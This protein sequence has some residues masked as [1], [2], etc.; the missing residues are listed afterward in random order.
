MYVSVGL[1]ALG[2]LWILHG[3]FSLRRLNPLFDYLEMAGVLVIRLNSR[4]E[5]IQ[6]HHDLVHLILRLIRRYLLRLRNEFVRIL[7]LL[8]GEKPFSIRLIHVLLR[9]NPERHSRLQLID[10]CLG[11][12]RA[13]PG[14]RCLD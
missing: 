5:P 14:I 9:D 13:Q 1:D 11:F 6:H 2:H 4:R 10:S 7:D 8:V 12:L 3:S